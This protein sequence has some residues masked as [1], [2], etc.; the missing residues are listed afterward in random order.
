M[1]RHD[2]PLQVAGFLNAVANEL[3]RSRQM[4]PPITSAHEAYAVMLEELDEFKAEVW[5]K[6]SE[7]DP[8]AMRD[9]LIQLAAMCA[10]TAIDLQLFAH[11]D[12]GYF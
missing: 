11:T 12:A 9:E 4:H 6:S 1:K 5:K 3:E 7:R 8:A 2:P 10:K